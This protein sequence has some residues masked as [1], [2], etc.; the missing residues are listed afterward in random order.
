M[1]LYKKIKEF[2]EISPVSSNIGD[3]LKDACKVCDIYYK[4]MGIDSVGN[5][6]QARIKEKELENLMKNI[7]KK[8]EK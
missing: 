6:E 4:M 1:S 5:Y 3:Y 7:I 2:T 8:W